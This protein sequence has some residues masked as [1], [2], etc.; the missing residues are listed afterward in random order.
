MS[1]ELIFILESGEKISSRD[2]TPEQVSNSVG[3]FRVKI[4]D[5][6]SKTVIHKH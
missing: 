1:E 5:E 2:I 3:V 4:N 6:D